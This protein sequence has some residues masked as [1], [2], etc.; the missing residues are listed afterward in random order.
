MFCKEKIRQR[1]HL[2]SMTNERPPST[3]EPDLLPILFRTMGHQIIERL[4]QRIFWWSRVT[5]QEGFI[6]WCEEKDRYLQTKAE[7]AHYDELAWW[8]KWWYWL[9]NI[10]SIISKKKVLTGWEGLKS[11]TPWLA[12]D[13][14]ERKSHQF[15]LGDLKTNWMQLRN[16]GWRKQLSDGLPH[17]KGIPAIWEAA[18]IFL[19]QLPLYRD[20]EKKSKEGKSDMLGNHSVKRRPLSAA[21]VQR[22]QCCEAFITGLEQGLR[23]QYAVEVVYETFVKSNR[24]EDIFTDTEEK[25]SDLKARYDQQTAA[26]TDWISKEGRYYYDDDLALLEKEHRAAWEK[27]INRLQQIPLPLAPIV[28]D[29]KEDHRKWL[30]NEKKQK[31]YIERGYQLGLRIKVLIPLASKWEKMVQD[32]LRFAKVCGL[33]GVTKWHKETPE[34]IYQYY[35]TICERLSEPNTITDFIDR[36][37][38]NKIKKNSKELEKKRMQLES[39]AVKELLQQPFEEALKHSAERYRQNPSQWQ[40]M[41]KSHSQ[42]RLFKATLKCH[43]EQYRNYREALEGSLHLQKE[44][45]KWRSEYPAF[46]NAVVADGALPS[47]VEEMRYRIVLFGVGKHYDRLLSWCGF[48]GMNPAIFLTEGKEGIERKINHFYRRRIFECHPDKKS[49]QVTIEAEQEK[50]IE[51]AIRSLKEIENK[52]RDFLNYVRGTELDLESFRRWW[53]EENSH[54]QAN[55]K[56]YRYTV[57]WQEGYYTRQISLSKMHYTELRAEN[58]QKDQ[59][60]VKKDEEIGRK[61]EEI[62]R[63]DKENKQILAQLAQKEEMIKRLL[64]SLPT[65]GEEQK[66]GESA[67]MNMRYPRNGN[68][69]P[70]LFANRDNK[71]GSDGSASEPKTPTEEEQKRP[72]WHQEKRDGF[73][74]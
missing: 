9:F 37:L 42:S 16:P 52:R 60:L 22:F 2:K 31:E 49:G 4:K 19:E 27:Y 66:G 46:L 51:A 10:Q 21:W 62:G 6:S 63:K 59:M 20:E 5:Y 40:A 30:L 35:H 11:F 55:K 7:V 32:E 65:N 70:L 13:R 74:H 1:E 43:V 53:T 47:L 23:Q 58:K 3:R 15:V 45:R 24:G 26:L 25:L 28:S 39:V 34:S 50:I 71:N 69:S 41:I 72:G 36:L 29:Q 56:W 18:N 14:D 54:W 12:W 38:L 44:Y 68:Y 57:F 33:L 73:R 8:K 67:G 61:D 64:K 17:F 48:F